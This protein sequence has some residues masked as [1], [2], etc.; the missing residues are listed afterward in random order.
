LPIIYQGKLKGILYL[1]NNLTK[2]AFTAERLE[3]LNLLSSQAAISLENASLYENLQIYSEKLEQ[4]NIELK[5]EIEERQRVK[6]AL[7]QSEERLRLAVEATAL[8]TW[9]SNLI[10][11]EL[12]WSDRC[13]AL[14]GL[15]PEAEVD[16][17]RFLRCL[18]P[19][20]RERTD[21]AIQQ[22]LAPHSNG[23]YN[24][25]Y[26]TLGSDGTVRWIAARGRA[27]NQHEPDYRFIGTVLDITDRKLAQE[28]IQASLEEKVVLLK[29]IHH[30]VKN[31]LQIISSLLSLQSSYI[32][33]PQ[34]QAILQE[35]QNRVSSMAL[36]HEQLYESENFAKIDFAEYIHNLIANL[37][38]SYETYECIIEWKINIDNIFLDLDEA[39]PCA[40]IINELVSNSLKYAFPK[41]DRGE[42][43]INFRQLDENSLCLTI[44]DN[45]IGIPQ[46]LDLDNTNT[47]GL[48]L[49]KALTEQLQGN[50][51][52]NRNQGTE[53][54]I[55]FEEQNK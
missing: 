13:K 18:H 34:T 38:S 43:I 9:D 54:K 17:D 10:T 55:L 41:R 31:N 8:G 49:V 28:Q 44:K 36:I 29:E 19:D 24:I 15:S 22:A 26:R 53:F 51:V 47:L 48:Q 45:G 16:Y 6:S 5:A 14:F 42:I 3:V 37:S 23:E 39:I 27:F 46:D 32:E 7:Q 12:G 30:R 50:L 11:G 21:R 4:Q 25:E 35:C 33:E 2:E 52:L 40:L 20:D 1:E